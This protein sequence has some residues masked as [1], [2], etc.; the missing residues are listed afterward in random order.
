M[1]DCLHGVAWMKNPVLGKL[2]ISIESSTRDTAVS[3]VPGDC[4]VAASGRGGAEGD[5]LDIE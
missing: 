1:Q 4:C 2:Y 3:P 5:I